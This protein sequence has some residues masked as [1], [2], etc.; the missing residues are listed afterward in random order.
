MIVQIGADGSVFSYGN[1]FYTGSVPAESPLRKR[2]FSSPIDA[3]NSANS[4]LELAVSGQPVAEAAQDTETYTITGTTGA[5]SDPEAK[6]VYFVKNDALA[7]SWRV[8][9]DVYNDWLLTYVDANDNT[10]LHGAVNYKADIDA[11]YLVYPWGTNDPSE[12]GAERQSIVN[13]W[14]TVTS[15]F[16][17]HGDGAVEY[18]ATRGNNVAAQVNPGG[19]ADATAWQTNY[20]PTAADYNFSYPYDVSTTDPASY[21][22]AATTQLFYTVNVYHDVLYALG[23]TEAAG[24]FES[25]NNVR[26]SALDGSST[27]LTYLSVIRDKA[28]WAETLPF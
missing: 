11:T 26:N 25:N 9:T 28:V 6:L 19:S 10:K 22:D 17:Y 24:N 2:D 15:E 1:G 14:S 4:L 23:F 18:A 5:V 13:P 7:L 21:R 12:A 3:L 8:E 16:T 20:R 27:L